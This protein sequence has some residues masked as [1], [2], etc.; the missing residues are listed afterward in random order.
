[1][2]EI[3]FLVILCD[4]RNSGRDLC[5]CF[6]R[7][8]FKENSGLT[9]TLLS[10]CPACDVFEDFLGF[11]SVLFFNSTPSSVHATVSF[12]PVTLNSYF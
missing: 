3:F 11:F 6:Q 10:K 8:F 12:S 9:Y 7:A 5:L 2:P 1:M 4:I